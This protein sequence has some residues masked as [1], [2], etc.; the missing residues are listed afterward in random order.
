[1]GK[2]VYYYHFEDDEFAAFK[3]L[4]GYMQGYLDYRI[5]LDEQEQLIEFREII[6]D[7]IDRVAEKHVGNMSCS[8]REHRAL[9]FMVKSLFGAHGT[10]D[11]EFFPKEKYG[12]NRI[13]KNDEYFYGYVY[14]DIIEAEAE[15]VEDD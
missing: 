5:M 12:V 6:A 13:L 9:V 10:A 2:I 15:W 7:I 14:C 1:M 8:K 11:F 3:M 4:L